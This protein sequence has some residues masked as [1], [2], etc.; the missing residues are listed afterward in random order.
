MQKSI[1]DVKSE[2][3]LAVDGAERRVSSLADVQIFFGI[4]FNSPLDFF[5]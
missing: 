1:N 4:N 2:T 5:C 3:A